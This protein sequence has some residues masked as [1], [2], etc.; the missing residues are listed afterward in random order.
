MTNPITI[1]RFQK[2]LVDQIIY[3]MERENVSLLEAEIRVA[4]MVSSDEV[5]DAAKAKVNEMNGV[6]A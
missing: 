3:F 4:G 6:A 2:Q 1:K 5:I